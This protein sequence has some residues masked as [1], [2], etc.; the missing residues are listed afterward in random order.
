MRVEAI[1]SS[2]SIPFFF[3][4]REVEDMLL[5]DGGIFANLSL[6]DP[7]ERCRE[8]GYADEDIIVDAILCYGSIQHID[9]W[10]IG[11]NMRWKNAGNFYS[12][13]KDITST[14]MNTEDYQRLIRGYHNVDFRF[15]FKPSKNLTSGFVAVKA[16]SE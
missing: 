2:T 3:P 9:E 12:R 7:I 16:N 5:V 6:G 4:P 8:E 15:A 11:E 13:R 14:A 1:I 10:E